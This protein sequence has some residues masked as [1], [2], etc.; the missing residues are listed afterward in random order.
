MRERDGAREGKGESEK[1]KADRERL[2]IHGAACKPRV[3]ASGERF[4]GERERDERRKE[5]ETRERAKAREIGKRGHWLFVARSTYG[6]RYGPTTA[7]GMC[8]FFLFVSPSSTWRTTLP[9]YSGG[10]G[11][12]GGGG[13]SGNGGS[14]E[15]LVGN[16]VGQQPTATGNR[17]RIEFDL[18]RMRVRE[19]VSCVSKR[20]GEN[21]HGR[22]V[23]RRGK[24][25]N[26]RHRKEKRGEIG[27]TG[28]RGCKRPRSQENQEGQP[29]EGEIMRLRDKKGDQEVN[30]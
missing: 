17:R 27:L 2:R 13:S 20:G 29:A 5:S 21:G 6:N 8:S 12:G 25:L 11:G 10:G 9:P 24:T 14:G 30:R 1:E 23:G 15:P 22:R 4:G 16:P 7:V 18:K 26:D 19:R 3:R 28:W